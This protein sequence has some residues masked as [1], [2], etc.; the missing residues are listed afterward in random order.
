MVGSQPPSLLKTIVSPFFTGFSLLPT[1][2]TVRAT[3]P[4]R[5]DCT[6]RNNTGFI[7]WTIGIQNYAI[8]NVSCPGCVLLA[9]GSLY[10]PSVNQSHAGRYTCVLF[11]GHPVETFSV[12]LNIAGQY[13]KYNKRCA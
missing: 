2:V 3:F 12:Y 4:A 10:I 5:F 1:N 6:M 9:N 7:R 8:D 13:Y 11:I